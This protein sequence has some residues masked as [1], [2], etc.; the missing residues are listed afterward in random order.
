MSDA[1]QIY[2]VNAEKYYFVV[3]GEVSQQRL[4]ENG[5]KTFHD[6]M[7]MLNYVMSKLKLSFVEVDGREIW[8]EFRGGQWKSSDLQGGWHECE[9]VG[10]EGLSIETWLSKFE[11]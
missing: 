5:C 9:N 2:V 1:K 6:L 4:H 7:S 10:Q 3:V 11:L 8:I